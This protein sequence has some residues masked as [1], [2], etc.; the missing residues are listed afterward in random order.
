MGYQISRVRSVTLD[1]WTDEQVQIILNIG[2]RKSNNYYELYNKLAH[3]A[4]DDSSKERS[5]Y[6]IN[7]YIKR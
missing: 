2:N 7:K 6:I 3:L 5:E 4:S 1:S